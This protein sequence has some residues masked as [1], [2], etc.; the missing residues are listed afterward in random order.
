MFKNWIRKYRITRIRCPYCNAPRRDAFIYD[1]EFW[2]AASFCPEL[3]FGLI[4]H[5]AFPSLSGT[6]LT[7]NYQM[8][9]NGGQRIPI[10][11]ENIYW[12]EEVESRLEEK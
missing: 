3:H 11:K 8:V 7:L 5:F 10:P 1:G 6:T 9:D 2:P 4:Y 12:R